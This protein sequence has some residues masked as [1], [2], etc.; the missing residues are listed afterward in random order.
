MKRLS[1]LCA[2]ALMGSAM[3]V[4]QDQPQPQRP[5]TTPE[6]SNTKHAATAGSIRAGSDCWDCW[7]SRV[8]AGASESIAPTMTILG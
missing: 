6:P 5:D 1:M 8:A 3:A 2:I 4:A 7:D